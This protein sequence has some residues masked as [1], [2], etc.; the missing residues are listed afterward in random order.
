MSKTKEDFPIHH[1]SKRES[2]IVVFSIVINTFR[3]N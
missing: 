2:L 3:S 1:Y